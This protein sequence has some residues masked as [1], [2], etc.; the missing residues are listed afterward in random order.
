MK[1]I[2]ITGGS[3][4]IGTKLCS[5]LNERGHNVRSFD[6]QDNIFRQAITAAGTGCMA[7][8]ESEKFMAEME[9][10]ATVAAE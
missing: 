4:F 7:A 3:G 5:L 10:Q 6:V 1:R 9:T 2:F 8:L